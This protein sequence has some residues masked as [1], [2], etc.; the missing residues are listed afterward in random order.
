MVWV[1]IMCI[2]M[3]QNI[4]QTLG[5]YS[6]SLKFKVIV[7]VLLLQEPQRLFISLI[8]ILGKVVNFLY[9]GYTLFE[10][11]C[12]NFSTCSFC[13][14]ILFNLYLSKK[15]EENYINFVKSQEEKTFYYY[16]QKQKQLQQSLYILLFPYYLQLF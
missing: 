15:A 13:H 7:F 3:Y 2:F 14:F 1:Y 10:I 4:Q 8:F 6:K 16:Q 11:S 9:I 12:A 5:L